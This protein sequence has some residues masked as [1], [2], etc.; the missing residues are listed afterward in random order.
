[1]VATTIAE[2]R[3]AEDE[4][5]TDALAYAAAARPAKTA[6][7]AL[8]SG[9]RL[10]YAE[11]T[12]LADRAAGW[13]ASRLGETQ[14]ERVAYL[15]RN[16]VEL[17]V[18]ALGAER[19]GAIFVPLNWRLAGPEIAALLEDCAPRL[20]VAQNEFLPLLVL[21][22]GVAAT[23]ALDEIRTT[24]PLPAQPLP[25][26][27]PIILLYTSG[28][29]GRPKG[30]IVTAR[31][32]FAAALNFIAVGEV[33]AGSV[34]LS[35]LPM[36]H[37][38]GL[39]AVARSTLMAGGTLVLTDRFLVP[40]TLA[41]LSDA[42][43]GV[44]HYFAV[45]MMAEALAADAAFDAA[46]L[47][48]LHAIFLG[49][50]PPAPALIERFLEFGVPLVNGYGMSEAGTAIHVPIDR[51]AVRRS[52]GAVGLP[53]PH[54]E[55][56]LVADGAD[57]RAGDVG[58]VWLRGPSVTPGY[59]NRP[60]ETA[61]AF[62]EGW[63]RTGDLA[64]REMSGMYRIVDRLKDMYVSGGENVYPAEVEAVVAASGAVADAAVL[65]IADARWG[66]IGVAFVV[67]ED[68]ASFDPDALRAHCAARLAKYKCPT[69][70]VVVEAIPRSAAGKILKPV[71][72][73]R[74]MN[75][76]FG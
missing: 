53:A 54:I 11:L 47:K 13:L 4:F 17:L 31:N 66:E 71:L 70:V 68:A 42:A 9:E 59:W 18:L 60:A 58:E 24:A 64:R 25:V 3:L 12:A 35:D 10:A 45:P 50:A 75:G 52:A 55:I 69:R 72:R 16:G 62:A 6:V 57:V 40:R 28:T 37:T 8:A 29:T 36:F 15:G 51:E 43:L 49:G 1:M 33:H 2:E 7:V 5:S 34:T 26:H 19:C 27:R 38:I 46:A 30:V 23:G 67:P 73:E 56:R 20:V 14:G 48:R 76:E 39:I 74:L 65:G 63:Y 44:T 41:A 22:A 21:A 32:A 61:A